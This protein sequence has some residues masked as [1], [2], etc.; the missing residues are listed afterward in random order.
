MEET[1]IKLPKVIV[2][3]WKTLE[4][5]KVPIEERVKQEIVLSMVRKHTIS[6]SRGAE[7]LGMDYQDFLEL[8]GKNEIPLFDYK[9]G[10]IKRDVETLEELEKSQQ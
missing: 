8:M 1:T 3:L 4:K 10:E 9:A 5:K 2:E 7:L 6:A